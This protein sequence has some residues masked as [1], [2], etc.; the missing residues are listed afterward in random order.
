MHAYYI[1]MFAPTVALPYFGEVA[2][3]T[4][5]LLVKGEKGYKVYMYHNK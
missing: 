5:A 4:R 1:Y 3:M 2:V